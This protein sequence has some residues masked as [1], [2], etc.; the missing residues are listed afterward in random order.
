MVGGCWFVLSQQQA[1]LCRSWQPAW[2]QVTRV[3]FCSKWGNMFYKRSVILD[4]VQD[5]KAARQA[6]SGPVL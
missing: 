4:Y 3:A 6:P 1:R 2:K 5:K